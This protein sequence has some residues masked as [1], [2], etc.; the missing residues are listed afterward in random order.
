MFAI[1]KR[2]ELNADQ[3]RNARRKGSLPQW[4]KTAD[5][6][7]LRIHPIRT[8]KR[9]GAV[10]TWLRKNPG[11]EVL[12]WMDSSKWFWWQNDS[13]CTRAQWRDQQRE[14]EHREMLRIENQQRKYANKLARQSNKC[15]EARRQQ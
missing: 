1:Y 2:S 7:K 12:I 15:I 10:T 6:Q 4:R 14:A 9:A 8:C 3:I 5:G 11:I 13:L